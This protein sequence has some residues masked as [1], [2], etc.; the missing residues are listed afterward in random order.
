[1]LVPIVAGLIGYIVFSWTGNDK[2]ANRTF[3]ITV[4]VAIGALVISS[5]DFR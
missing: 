3:W 1:M 4:A 2:W 5:K